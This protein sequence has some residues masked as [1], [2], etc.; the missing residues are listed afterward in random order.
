MNKTTKRLLAL[1]LAVCMLATVL[2]ACGDN[3]GSSSEP[4]SSESTPAEESS[5]QV[6]SET[7]EVS[8]TAEPEG[9]DANWAPPAPPET[10][11]YNEISEYYYNYN[12]G[13]FYEAYQTASA[14]LL[15]VNKR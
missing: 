14:E 4:A 11:D 8:S 15:D 13:E 3:T 10:D 5:S 1:L 2:A 6:S 12:L 7:G 9:G